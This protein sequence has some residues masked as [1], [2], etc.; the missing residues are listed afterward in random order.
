MRDALGRERGAGSWAGRPGAE[1]TGGLSREKGQGE[2]LFLLFC[3]SL[4]FLYYFLLFPI[5][6]ELEHDPQI[7]LMYNKI[8]HHMKYIYDPA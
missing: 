4:F 6:L 3:F 1:H 7:K 2:G 8:T 5:K